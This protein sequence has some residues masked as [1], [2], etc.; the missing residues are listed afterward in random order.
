MTATKVA[1]VRGQ[2]DVATVLGAL[3]SRVTMILPSAI[4]TV[5]ALLNRSGGFRRTA[6]DASEACDEVGPVLP[7]LAA[8]GAVGLL[9]AP[10]LSPGGV[11]GLVLLIMP[12]PLALGTGLRL[13]E[14]RR[15]L[16]IA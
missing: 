12:Y 11:V 15:L 16:G 13:S 2:S 9:V 10:Q 1:A 5:D 3:A 4:G 14:Y 6:K 8:F 7:L